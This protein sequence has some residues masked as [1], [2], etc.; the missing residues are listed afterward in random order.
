MHR[1]P[2]GKLRSAA[3]AFYRQEKNE[4]NPFL[5]G[6]AQLAANEAVDVWPEN[7]PAFTVFTRLQTQWR[8]GMN[9]Q[10]GLDYSALFSF[11]DRMDLEKQEREEIFSD[12]QILE[13]AALNEIHKQED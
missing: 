2:L 8:H 13:M 7:W 9:G 12:V 4:T 10:T 11:L 6:I 5:A 1:G 3:S